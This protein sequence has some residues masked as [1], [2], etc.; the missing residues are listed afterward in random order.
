MVHFLGQGKETPSPEHTTQM[1]VNST[2][3]VTIVVVGGM[4]VAIAFGE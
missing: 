2:V 1:K 4:V 3:M